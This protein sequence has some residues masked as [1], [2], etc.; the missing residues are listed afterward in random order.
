TGQPRFV[1]G[2]FPR[3]GDLHFAAQD[4][5]RSVLA[6]QSQLPPPEFRALDPDGA[7]GSAFLYR[8]AK[9]RCQI[10]AL[11]LRAARPQLRLPSA[12]FVQCERSS[13]R[14]LEI[15]APEFPGPAWNSVASEY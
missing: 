11:P 4:T 1:S 6:I 5:R 15:A 13:A 3:P 7:P 14:P 9:Y 8:S 12:L 10:A 2:Q